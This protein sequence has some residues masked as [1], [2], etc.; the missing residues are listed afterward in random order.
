[1]SEPLE[2]FARAC[3]AE[4]EFG[5][6]DHGPVTA[7]FDDALLPVRVTAPA[8]TPAP[9]APTPTPAQLSLFGDPTARKR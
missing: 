9:P 5:T 8:P 4:R 6:S 7:H 3:V 1:V 2:R